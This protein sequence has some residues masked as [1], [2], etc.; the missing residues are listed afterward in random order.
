MAGQP[1]QLPP[2]RP[3]P[4]NQFNGAGYYEDYYR[5]DVARRSGKFR[6]TKF[7]SVLG[8]VGGAALVAASVSLIAEQNRSPTKQKKGVNIF[9]I[10]A[11]VIGSVGAFYSVSQLMQ[12]DVPTL[13]QQ[14]AAS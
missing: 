6:L 13:Q 14:Y 9:A 1:P 4:V 11:A 7:Q 8:V 3:I 12:R 2:R 5:Q 10:V